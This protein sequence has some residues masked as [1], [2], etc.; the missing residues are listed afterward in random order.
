MVPRASKTPV[1]RQYHAAKQEHPDCL[2]FFRLGDFFELFFEDAATASEA[3]SITLT[4][5]RDGKGV[6][7]PMC[8]V[9][10]HSAETYVAKLLRKGHRVAICDQVE[11]PTKGRGLVRREVVQVLSPGTTSDPKLLKDDENNYLAAIHVRG[12]NAGLAYL[13]ITTG[14][15]RVTEIPAAEAPDLLQSLS[16]REV[17]VADSASLPSQLFETEDERQEPYCRQTSVERWTFDFDYAERLVLEH[18]GLHSLI[19]LGIE[20]A[21]I[22]VSTAGALLH[23]VKQTQRTALAHI[24]RPRFLEQKD[25]MVIDPVTIRHLEIFDPMY[26]EQTTTLLHALD[27]TATSMGARLMRNWVRRPSVDS[28]VI[29]PRLG[30]VEAMVGDLIVRSEVEGEMRQIN[31]IERIVARINLG[32]A[33]PRDTALLG[34]SLRRVHPI[35]ALASRLRAP[36]V[37]QL[38]EAM[39][40]LADVVDR[41]S[42]TLVPNPPH[43]VREGNIVAA[44]YDIELDQLRELQQ[45][46]RAFIARLEKN[47][48]EVTGIES[49][50]VRFNNVFGFFIEVSKANLA[51]VPEHYRRR[52]TLANAE[53]YSTT[54]LKELE[55]KVLDA[56]ERI[57]QMEAAI[58]E[59]LRVEIMAQSQRIRATAVAVAELDALRSLAQVAAEQDYVR[60]TFSS[61]GELHIEG[62]RHPV[63]ERVLEACGERFIENDTFLDSDERQVAIIT[64][65][66]MGGKS[67]YLRQTAIISVMAQMGSFVPAR[68]ASLPVI[69]RIFTR[70][71]ASDNLA[72]GRSTF[73]VEMTETAQILNLATDRSLILLDEVGRGTSTYDGL[74]IAWAVAEY[75]RSTVHAKTLFATHYHELTTLPEAHTGIFNLHVSARQSG[76]RLVFL[77]RV[78]AG[79]ADRSYGIEV[80]RL[81]G[82]PPSVTTR[83]T[84][85]LRLHENG[86]SETHSPPSGERQASIYET[87]PNGI[88][89]ELASLDLDRLGPL[90]ALSLVHDWKQRSERD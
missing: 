88:A 47:E 68:R 31:D 61:E 85:V 66:N 13:D 60:P 7:I 26:R 80:A 71:G 34:S 62:G 3:L 23:Y 48:R 22:A 56:E 19:G 72:Q 44:G 59:Q 18:F 51:K 25:W 41:I 82:L 84:E 86:A 21:Q 81:A 50:K 76:E 83:A 65:P 64:G 16:V 42:Q 70:I 15:F 20:G 43:S 38:I 69:D 46:S 17:L 12:P 30:A 6:Y 1:M 74:A 58:F 36:R 8:G 28:A 45:N 27:R 10:A 78:E 67:T 39:D 55:A 9:P 79:K 73:M 49:L 11:P 77:R 54:E 89:E 5:R 24:D 29:E 53:R 57:G 4:K 63:V 33:G 35:K 14:E 87:M 90:E 52:Q 37:A 2:L 32:T 75:I 40:D